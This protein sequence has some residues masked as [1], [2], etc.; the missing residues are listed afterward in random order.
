MATAL[1]DSGTLTDGGVDPD[2]FRRALG[3]FL[4]GVTIVTT[5]GADGQPIGMTAN[6]FTSVSLDPPLV[7][8]SV[9]RSAA[10][11]AA[12]E[13]AQRYAVHILHRHQHDVSSAF[14]RSAAGGAQKFDGVAW[15]SSADGLPVLDEYLARID[16]TITQRVELGDHV[17][18]IARVD[19]AE[20][21]RGSGPLAFFRGR[22]SG[23]AS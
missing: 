4:T 1:A 23:L 2:S 15:H 6:S 12:M 16:C 18:Y 14:A 13:Q 10:S 11:F 3:C 7:L 9:A 8:V 5:I 17:G 22:Y 20:A 21:G 19:A